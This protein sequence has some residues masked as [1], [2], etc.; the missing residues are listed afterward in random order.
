MTDTPPSKNKLWRL[1]LVV[2]VLVG[3]YA[4][5]RATGLLETMDAAM[6]RTLVVDAGPWGAL[7]FVALFTVGLL[8]HIPGLVFVASGIF[9]YGRLNGFFVGLIGAEVA[10]CVSFV[11]VRTLGGNALTGVTRPFIQRMLDRLDER[12]IQWLVILRILM[13]LSPPLNYALAMSRI[14]FR[15]YAIGTGLG[16]V[17]PIAVV[18]VLFDWLL[19]QG[20]IAL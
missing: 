15:D 8:L 19:Q 5:A 3:L 4:V 13:V 1:A 12:P 10:A 2:V 16:L 20:W 7:V 11:V 14:R 9:V 6:L 18:S 17:V